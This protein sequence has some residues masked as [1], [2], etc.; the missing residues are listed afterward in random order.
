MD[1]SIRGDELLEPNGNG[2]VLAIQESG[3]FL[4]ETLLPEEQAKKLNKV[5]GR[6]L[7]MKDDTSEVGKSVRCQADT[8][9]TK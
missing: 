8:T 7:L 6:M 5:S 4:V 2:W 9:I 3:S 1:F